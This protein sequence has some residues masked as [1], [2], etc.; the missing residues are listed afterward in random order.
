MKIFNL[1]KVSGIIKIGLAMIFS[2]LLCSSCEDVPEKKNLNQ[3]VKKIVL[4][5]DEEKLAVVKH[6]GRY[7]FEYLAPNSM[8]EVGRELW[9]VDRGVTEGYKVDKW[10]VNSRILE[11]LPYEVDANDSVEENGTWVLHIN[12]TLCKAVPVMIKFDSAHIVVKKRMSRNSFIEISTGDYVDEE[13]MIEFKAK[14][15]PS[16]KEIDKW[17]MNGKEL[18]GTTRRVDVDEAIEEDGK[19]VINVTYTLK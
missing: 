17:F 5:F 11:K 13:R 8:F 10:K 7:D 19:K 16:G 9:F 15:L 3:F 6:I 12:Y 2:L 4:K 14:N 1:K 18:D